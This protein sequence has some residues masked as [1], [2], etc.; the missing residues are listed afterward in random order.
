MRDGKPVGAL[1]GLACKGECGDD[2][3][4]PT[5]QDLIVFCGPDA[6]IP[7][8]EQNPLAFG[9]ASFRFNVQVWFVW[10]RF[11]IVFFSIA[12]V[13]DVIDAVKSCG[14]FAEEAGNVCYAPDVDFFFFALDICVKTAGD[15]TAYFDHF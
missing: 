8:I 6:F 10:R 15:T 1:E 9:H 4:V 7:L 14:V 5:G 13:A 2:Q 12:V 11:R 3:S